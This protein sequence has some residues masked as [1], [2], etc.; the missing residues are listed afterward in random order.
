M[1]SG[2]VNTTPILYQENKASMM[3]YKKLLFTVQEIIVYIDTR[4]AHTNSL[5]THYVLVSMTSS[6]LHKLLY[7][8]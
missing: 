6:Y 2:H 1:L 8:I 4:P 5:S 7:F 3:K